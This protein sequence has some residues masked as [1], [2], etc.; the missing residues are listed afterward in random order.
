MASATN[1]IMP[2]SRW[3]AVNPHTLKQFARYARCELHDG[4][5][6]GVFGHDE[7][8]CTERRGR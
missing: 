7:R 2:I 4:L 6:G 1:S 3:Y 8:M 5:V